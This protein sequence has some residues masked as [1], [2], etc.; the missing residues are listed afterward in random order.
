MNDLS[1]VRTA[2]AGVSGY[3]RIS[4]SGTRVSS[5]TW[6]PLTIGQAGDLAFN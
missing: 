2:G 1:V 5:P 3:K 6:E 4:T